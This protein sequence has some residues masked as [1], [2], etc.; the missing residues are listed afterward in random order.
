MYL[1]A[2]V[3]G[4]MLIWLVIGFLLTPLVVEIMQHFGFPVRGP[5]FT[6]NINAGYALFAIFLVLILAVV[7]VGKVKEGFHRF[8]NKIPLKS[9]VIGVIGIMLIWLTIDFLLMP[10]G[11]TWVTREIGG[12]I[13]FT[14]I[15]ALVAG[16]VLVGRVKEVFH[17]FAASIFLVFHSF[18]ALAWFMEPVLYEMVF[19]VGIFALLSSPLN[20]LFVFPSTRWL[21][22]V[23]VISSTYELTWWLFLLGAC[24]FPIGVVIFAVAF[25]QLL[26][27]KDGLVT[28]GL[29]SVVRHPQ[30]LGII[31]ATLGFTFFEIEVKLVS[32]I[33]WIMLVFIYLWLARREETNLQEKHGEEFLAYKRRVPLILP[34]PTSARKNA[35]ARA[36]HT[37]L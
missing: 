9:L 35:I 5:W 13:F 23:V 4:I 33:A 7:F 18:P 1:K 29:Y 20:P 8:V 11:M 27:G 6:H 22:R 17:R 3:I 34:L 16:S 26:K 32:L 30:Y 25:I 31:L 14:I 28:S 24:L 2:L 15:L 19:P 37:E 21:L 36:F 12:Y 10:P